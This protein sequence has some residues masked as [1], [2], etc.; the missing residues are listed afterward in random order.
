MRGTPIIREVSIC[1]LVSEEYPWGAYSK[2]DI[3]RRAQFPPG[4]QYFYE[5]VRVEAVE[6][7]I[8]TYAC[9]SVEYY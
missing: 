2:R 8:F 9:F 5:T 4:I 6:R 7:E 1:H 3:H